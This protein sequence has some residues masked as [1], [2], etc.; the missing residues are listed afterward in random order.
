MKKYGAMRKFMFFVLLSILG[1]YCIAA[2][3]DT[4][5]NSIQSLMQATYGMIVSVG[6]YCY[7]LC[8]EVKNSVVV[9]FASTQAHNQNV[10][11]QSLDKSIHG[12][13][14][15]CTDNQE[16]CIYNEEFFNDTYITGE[17]DGDPHSHWDFDTDPFVLIRD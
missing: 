2:E 12:D 1:S 5:E 13:N 8:S 15:Q 6:S 9:L 14:Y 10:A 11:I 3:A 7:K 17:L 16:D 4:H